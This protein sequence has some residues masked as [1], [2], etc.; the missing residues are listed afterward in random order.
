M[1]PSA[2]LQVLSVNVGLPKAVVWKGRTV[3]TGIFKEP[4]E[5]RVAIR[6]LN[7]EGDRQADLTVHGGTDKAVYVYP[8][9]YYLFWREQFPEMELPWGMFGE[10]LTIAGALNRAPMEE[11]VHIGDRFQVG[12]AQLMVTQ[13]RLPCYKLGLKF[14]RD[15]ILKRF[16]QS[17]LTGFYFAVLKEGEV[18]AG[19]SIRLLHRDEHQ[20]KVADITRLYHQDKHNLDLMRRVL[21][22]EALPEVW[23]TYFLQ[24]LTKLTGSAAAS[25]TWGGA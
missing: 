15:D 1:Q 17:G 25:E 11:T 24:R 13:P 3:V 23:R 22:V 6:R 4:V 21:A 12:S 5:G 10:N 18:A 16:L 9:E 20:V 7:L 8:A 2:T 19:D 14:G